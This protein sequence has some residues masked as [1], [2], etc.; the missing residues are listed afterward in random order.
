MST[1]RNRFFLSFALDAAFVAAVS[2]TLVGCLRPRVET[3]VRMAIELG[4]EEAWI[5][6]T[7]PLLPLDARQVRTVAVAA[8]DAT[9]FLISAA[10]ASDAV[11]AAGVGRLVVRLEDVVT[12][13]EFD[14]TALVQLT[15]P[16][17]QTWQASGR[18]KG[19]PT[20]ALSAAVL[21]AL[22]EAM[23]ESHADRL[24]DEELIEA[25]SSTSPSRRQIA[26][27]RLAARR[28]PAALEALSAAMGGACTSEQASA[29][30]GGLAALGDIR[31]VRAIIGALEG[32][33]DPSFSLQAIY[34]LGGL[35]GFEAEAY[36]FTLIA[37]HA[38]PRL[39]DAARE[40]HTTLLRNTTV[41]AD[42]GD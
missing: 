18:G 32:C 33:D 15:L 3:D 7:H 37:G 20:G 5:Y 23:W 36:L 34:V 21:A 39:R 30:L 17:G 4:A 10:Q 24:S 25:L 19:D 13:P 42:A 28:H 12:E 26:V 16:S 22:E 6:A 8:L 35:G 41:R 1:P 29:A 11:V 38:D 27:T 40:A 14:V 31:S 2:M 9:G